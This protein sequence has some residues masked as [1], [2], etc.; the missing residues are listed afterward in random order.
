M[1]VVRGDD[2]SSVLADRF[3]GHGGVALG[4]IGLPVAR[5]L[6]AR[7]YLLLAHLELAKEALLLLFRRRGRLRHRIVDSSHSFSFSTLVAPFARVPTFDMRETNA[8]D[9]RCA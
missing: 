7:R 5:F 8:G 2:W 3:G 9:T 4:R 1:R 6:A